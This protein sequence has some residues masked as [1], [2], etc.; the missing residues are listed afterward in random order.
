[1]EHQITPY[2]WREPGELESVDLLREDY[3]FRLAHR[4]QLFNEPFQSGDSGYTA[5]TR[6]ILPLC[7]RSVGRG[8]P[9]LLFSLLDD[10]VFT[11]DTGLMRSLLELNIKAGQHVVIKHTSF[12]TSTRRVRCLYC[13]VCCRWSAIREDSVLDTPGEGNVSRYF[14]E[15]EYA[16]GN[17]QKYVVRLSDELLTQYWLRR[18]REYPSFSAR[19]SPST[20][21]A[22]THLQQLNRRGEKLRQLYCRFTTAMLCLDRCRRDLLE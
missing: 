19:Q 3:Y 9:M 14:A 13:A 22:R 20:L 2:R 17:S 4:T 18:Y 11:D 7:T 1:V 12:S 15:G 16:V 10:A 6:P 8:V 21:S 5:S